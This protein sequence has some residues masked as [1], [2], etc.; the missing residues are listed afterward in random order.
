MDGILLRQQGNRARGGAARQSKGTRKSMR[1][2]VCK[3]HG[4]QASRWQQ[5]RRLGVPVLDHDDAIQTQGGTEGSYQ[6][7][8]NKHQAAKADHA[9]WKLSRQVRTGPGSVA[10]GPGPRPGRLMVRLRPTLPRRPGARGR[11]ARLPGAAASHRSNRRL[12]QAPGRRRRGRQR[13]GRGQVAPC[14]GPDLVA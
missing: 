8:G 3:N 5:L 6:P 14:Q 11:R 13:R 2:T 10:S 12:R 7:D 4:G 9:P 1:P